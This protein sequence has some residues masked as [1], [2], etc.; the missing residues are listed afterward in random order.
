MLQFSRAERHSRERPQGAHRAIEQSVKAPANVARLAPLGI[1][2]TYATPEQSTAEM[3]DEL[4]RV[5]ELTKRTG[6]AT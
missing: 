3:R 4:R 2:Q 6:L 1:M 5:I